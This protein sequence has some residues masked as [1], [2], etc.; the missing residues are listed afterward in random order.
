M[1]IARPNFI[2][3]VS[4]RSTES[5]P[6]PPA[7]RRERRHR[8]ARRIV[9]SA[10]GNPEHGRA[11]V[12]RGEADRFEKLLEVGGLMM[13]FAR[14]GDLDHLLG[15]PR[16]ERDPAELPHAGPGAKDLERAL[17]ERRRRLDGDCFVEHT[18]AGEAIALADQIV[19]ELDLVHD[20][21][22][23]RQPRQELH[24]TGRAPPAPAAGGGDID[25]A[26]VRRLE[27]R[28]AWRDRQRPARRGIARIGNE[29]AGRPWLHILVVCSRAWK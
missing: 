14:Q 29:R 20:R 7:T 12:G 24:A 17:V 27:N 16:I 18:L 11:D 10:D 4:P 19:A 28:G 1:S 2:A 6:L 25:A 23:R 26:R 13:L 9:A 21:R 3:A 15:D 8:H 5:D 22:R